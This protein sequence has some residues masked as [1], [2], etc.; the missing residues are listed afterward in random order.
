MTQVCNPTP[1]PPH[2]TSSSRGSYAPSGPHRHCMHVVHTETSRCTHIYIN[3]DDNDHLL[4]IF[5]VEF[6]ASLVY[7]VSSRMPKATQ[8]NPVLKNKNHN[9][10]IN[11]QKM[12][13]LLA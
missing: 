12:T 13:R 9:K 10:Q 3:N 7:R 4:K 2:S 8:R 6:E 5:I 11:K 1:T